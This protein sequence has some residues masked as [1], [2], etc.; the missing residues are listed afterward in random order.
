MIDAIPPLPQVVL[1]ENAATH[2]PT[3]FFGFMGVGDEKAL[4]A[5]EAAAARNKFPNGRTTN[6]K[7]Q[8]EVMI[9]FPVGS[10]QRNAVALFQDASA[11]KFGQLALEVIIAPLSAA[12]DGHVDMDKELSVEPPHVIVV[13]KR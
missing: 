7:K 10:D 9:L 6:D 1:V 13:P 4:K 8:L 11:G 3:F 12:A 5:L 2:Q